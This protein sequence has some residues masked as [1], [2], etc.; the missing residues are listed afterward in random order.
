MNNLQNIL[1]N[2]LR[3]DRVSQKFLYEHFYSYALKI[4][5][6]YCNNYEISVSVTNDAFIKMF[7]SLHLF[8]GQ[9]DNIENSFTAWLRRIVV[10][11]A[12]DQLRLQENKHHFLDINENDF[13]IVDN[14]YAD[15]QIMYKEMMQYLQKLPQ[16]HQLVFNLYVID[17]YTHN[18][19]AKLLQISEGTSKSHLFR[20]KQALQKMLTS[21]FEINK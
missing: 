14:D 16:Q 1:K 7:K 20:A 13:E 19:I 15:T 12:I 9:S 5:Y 11:K 8:N 17:G 10:N 3:Q 4:A 18:E 2:C 6:R 21:F